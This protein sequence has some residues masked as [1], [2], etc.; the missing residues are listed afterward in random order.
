[1]TYSPGFAIRRVLLATSEISPFAGDKY[2][3]SLET[4]TAAHVIIVHGTD[5]Y[6]E[7][8]VNR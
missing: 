8:K 7:D 2:L 5:R 6:S 1:M 4:M 3:L